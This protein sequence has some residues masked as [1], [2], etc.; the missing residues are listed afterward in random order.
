MKTA[1]DKLPKGNADVDNCL[2]F[3]YLGSLFQ[4]D[5]DRMPDIRD[6]CV[7]AKVRAGSFRHIWASTLRLGLKLRLYT[8]ACWSILV[9]GSEG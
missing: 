6:K 3:L 8:S 5:G 4:T 1:Q 7:R 9:Y 2:Q